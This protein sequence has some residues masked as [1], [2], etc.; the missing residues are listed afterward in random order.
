M[1]DRVRGNELRTISLRILVIGG[2]VLASCGGAD[3]ADS[4]T[5][6]EHPT[7]TTTSSTT[8]TTTPPTTT[9]TLSD[10]DV[11]D[12]FVEYM[13]DP[14]FTG[15]ADLGFQL[16]FEGASISGD[17]KLEFVGEISYMTMEIPEL[18]RQE[19]ISSGG[20]SYE[21]TGEGPWVSDEG[22]EDPFAERG[23]GSPVP[24]EEIAS[25]PVEDIEFLA[26]VKSIA[27][28]EHLGVEERDG[29]V[30]H[31]IGLPPGT[32]VDPMA[33]GMSPDEVAGLEVV[34]WATDTGLPHEMEMTFDVVE[35]PETPVTITFY[36]FFVETGI[37]VEITPPNKVWIR[38]TS[39]LGFSIGY[40]QNWEVEEYRE[41]YSSEV[42]FGLQGDVFEV[43]VT[44]VNPRERVPLNAVIS[45]F[46]SGG[47][48]EGMV[49][50]EVEELEIVGFPAR[51]VAYT[52]EDEFGMPFYAIY[53][54]TQADLGE[55]YEFIIWV[56]A[57]GE[58]GAAKLLEDFISTLNPD[59]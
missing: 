45:G 7:T 15:R 23:A 18:G 12:A 32:D 57:D 5:T 9:T 21:R 17:G 51:R 19:I 33:F 10:L 36:V 8:T 16:E 31:Q 26:A 6:T 4:T 34:F 42:F 59:V 25:V 30:L 35:D 1:A 46:R 43:V 55:M 41:E 11:L 47:E 40:P 44:D 58:E 29:I 38:H 54:V 22:D 3:A 49:F 48:Q 2:L 28:L 52:G 37:P 27:A 53:V 14:G 24:G 13:T 20:V 39:E 50:G 56:D